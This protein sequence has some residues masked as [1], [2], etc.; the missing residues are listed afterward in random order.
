LPISAHNIIK[1]SCE[2]IVQLAGKFSPP[3]LWHTTMIKI[4]DCKDELLDVLYG[5]LY[6][7]IYT[8]YYEW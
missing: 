4:K 8:N 5:W 6:T 7:N 1:I 2:S 3:H